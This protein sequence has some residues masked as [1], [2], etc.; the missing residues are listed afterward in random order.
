MKCNTQSVST[1][2]LSKG[3]KVVATIF[4]QHV[5]NPKDLRSLFTLNL[6]P[7]ESDE[8]ELKYENIRV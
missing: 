5:V 7:D 2:S 4:L 1:F 8:L 3:L 6:I